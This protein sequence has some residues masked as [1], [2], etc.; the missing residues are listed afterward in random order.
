MD[1]QDTSSQWGLGL[2]KGTVVLVDHNP[3]WQRAFEIEAAQIRAALGPL[4]IEIQHVGS[5]AIPN[6]RARPILDLMLGIADFD[7]G[8]LLEPALAQLGY[9]YV[10]HAGVP[11]DHVFGKGLDR[12]H[13]LHVVEHDGPD[14]NH[15]LRF[16]DRLRADPTLAQAYESLKIRLAEE[17]ADNRA[18]YTAAKQQFIVDA[19]KQR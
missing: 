2:R 13:L 18:A 4:A 11:N 19:V 7:Q 17:F 6:I 14:W 9:E 1:D 10:P 16:R 5:T 8:P 3:A 15:K 12:T